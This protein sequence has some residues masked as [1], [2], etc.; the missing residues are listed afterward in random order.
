MN[1]QNEENLPSQY[2]EKNGKSSVNHV[3]IFGETHT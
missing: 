3:D 1:K 2:G